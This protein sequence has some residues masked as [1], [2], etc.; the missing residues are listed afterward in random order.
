MEECNACS[1]TAR[2]H[3]HDPTLSE[4]QAQPCMHAGSHT[5]HVTLVRPH[6]DD[7]ALGARGHQGRMC[8]G[9]Q[10]GHAALGVRRHRLEGARGRGVVRTETCKHLSMCVCEHACVRVCACSV[11]ACACVCARVCA[12]VYVCVCVCACVFILCARVC[13][14]GG[15]A[16]MPIRVHSGL[17]R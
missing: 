6:F 16:R 4:K 2:L 8:V 10:G 3:A 5:H 17:R 11:C 1:S 15:R 13:V 7:L 14:V 9:D 12:C